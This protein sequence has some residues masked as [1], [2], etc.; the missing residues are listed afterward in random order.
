MT[1]L[2]A[3]ESPY[4]MSSLETIPLIFEFGPLLDAGETMSS[5]A[6]ALTNLT[7]GASTA[8]ML[9][10][11]PSA[12]GTRVTQSLTGLTTACSFLLTVTATALSGKI[13]T[14]ALKIN[15]PTGL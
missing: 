6:C 15:V 3:K 4:I 11:S 2:Y 13:W 9:S 14:I 1:T 7:T 10:G 12:S 8:G 5:P